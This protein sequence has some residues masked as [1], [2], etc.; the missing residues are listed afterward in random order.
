MTA[1]HARDA[2]LF[3]WDSRFGSSSRIAPRSAGVL[4]LRG[5][6]QATPLTPL[7]S[8]GRVMPRLVSDEATPLA[9]DPKLKRA[10][11]FWVVDN[12]TD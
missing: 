9:P 11:L 7:K 8:A 12:S 6:V 5:Q 4:R 10:V 3:R 2:V 1:S